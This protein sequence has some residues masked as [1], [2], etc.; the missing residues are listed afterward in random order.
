MNPPTLTFS[1]YNFNVRCR[2]T[3]N[4][5]QGFCS[6][7]NIGCDLNG[8]AC[9]TLPGGK[10]GEVCVPKCSALGAIYRS[11]PA[12]NGPP[13]ELLRDDKYRAFSKQRRFR[14]PAMFVATTDGMLHAFKAL[15]TSGVPAFDN[16]A[17]EHELWAFVPPAVLPRL[18]SNYPTGQQILLDGTPSVKDI[19]WDRLLRTEAPLY[20]TTLV[21]G[22]GAG[23]GGYYGLNVTD[24]D[25]QGDASTG[26]ATAPN[27]CLHERH[28]GRRREGHDEGAAVP[29]AAHGRRVERR[30]RTRKAAPHGA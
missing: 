14:R 9:S 6:V 8:P 1:G 30:G 24:S 22:L 18:A 25:C 5:T 21:S 12:V 2:D 20:H 13:N 17:A 28:L 19:V 7:S 23:G 16:V 27:G 26:I 3:S 10:V 15:S 4:P 11:T 29:L